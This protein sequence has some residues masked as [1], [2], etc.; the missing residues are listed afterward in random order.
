MEFLWHDKLKGCD[1]LNAKRKELAKE[2][3]QT[4]ASAEKAANLGVVDDI[5]TPADMR[6]AVSSALSMMEGKRV[7]NLPK[8]HTNF[9]Y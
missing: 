2:Y 5:I 4:L 9:P 6:A 1:D 3:S 8:K 7:T